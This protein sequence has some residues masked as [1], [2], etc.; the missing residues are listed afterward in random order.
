MFDLWQ[1]RVNANVVNVQPKIELVLGLPMLLQT[2][3]SGLWGRELG[4]GGVLL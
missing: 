3:Q 1:V 2:V 4:G